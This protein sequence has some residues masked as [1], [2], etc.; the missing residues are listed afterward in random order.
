MTKHMKVLITGGAGFIGSN[1]CRRLVADGDSV[2]VLDDLSTGSPENLDGVD[3]DFVRGTLLDAD[4]VRRAASGIDAIVHLG[5]LGSVPR[6]VKD[7]LASHHS[8]AR[9]ER[10]DRAAGSGS[11]S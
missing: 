6:S 2:R 11:F 3:V 10:R 8:H 4:Q 7:P 5:A 9:D 1:L